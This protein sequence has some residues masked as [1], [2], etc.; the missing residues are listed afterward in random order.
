MNGSIE[1]KPLDVTL[2]V[3]VRKTAE[4]ETE[5]IVELDGRIVTTKQ[6]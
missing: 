1:A 4:G 5:F 3:T 2:K 6:V